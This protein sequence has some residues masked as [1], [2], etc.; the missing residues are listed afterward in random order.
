[1]WFCV[2]V[3]SSGYSLPLG[4]CSKPSQILTDWGERSLPEFSLVFWIIV[5]SGVNHRLLSILH[6][7]FFYIDW[8]QKCIALFFAFPSSQLDMLSGVKYQHLLHLILSSMFVL[9]PYELGWKKKELTKQLSRPLLSYCS[10]HFIGATIYGL[11]FYTWDHTHVHHHP[12]PAREMSKGVVVIS[13]IPCMALVP[14]WW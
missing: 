3:C 1:M 6:S 5:G 10:Y 11:L 14:D 4:L 9:S 7:S 8:W 12:Q 2:G 13:E